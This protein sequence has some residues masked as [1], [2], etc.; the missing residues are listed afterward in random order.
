MLSAPGLHRQEDQP[1]PRILRPIPD[2]A[3]NVLAFRTTPQQVQDCAPAFLRAGLV[4]DETLDLLRRGVGFPG[5]QGS[6]L[7]WVRTSG[8]SG[9]PGTAP[10]MSGADTRR[11]QPPSLS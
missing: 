4:Q 3:G 1:R 9:G 2:G 10:C 7:S 8:R 11:A 6:L 5:L